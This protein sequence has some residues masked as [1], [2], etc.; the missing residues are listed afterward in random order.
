MKY[1]LKEP[2]IKSETFG[3]VVRKYCGILYPHMERITQLFWK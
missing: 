3:Q 1:T 2:E